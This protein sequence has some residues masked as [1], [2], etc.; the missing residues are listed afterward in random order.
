DCPSKNQPLESLSDASSSNPSSIWNVEA[1]DSTEDKEEHQSPVSILEPFFIDEIS[2]PTSAITNP[3]ESPMQPRHIDLEEHSFMPSPL[4]A[5][6][7]LGTCMEDQKSI[8]NYVRTVLQASRLNWEEL[9][10]KRLSSDQLLNPSLFDGVEMFHPGLLSDCI[11]EALLE[12][13][14]GYFGCPSWLF[15]IRPE[16]LCVPQEEKVVDKVMKEVH[17]NLRPPIM[18]RTLEHLVGN[19]M[20]KSAKWFDIRLDTEEIAIQIAE[21]VLQE[22]IMETILDTQI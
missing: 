13:Y 19:D 21:D 8:S 17:W 14:N 20:A 9:L 12:A 16:I 4:Y 15:P 3:A 5:N 10:V 2:S 11:Y 7:S 22:S 18:P 1:T 6:V